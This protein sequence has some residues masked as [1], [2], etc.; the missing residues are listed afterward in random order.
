MGGSRCAFVCECACV[1]RR[2]GGLRCAHLTCSKVYLCTHVRK[3]RARRVFESPADR[4]IYT[5]THTRA[6]THTHAHTHTCK[7]THTHTYAHAPPQHTPP[8]HTPCTDSVR[9]CRPPSKTPRTDFIATNKKTLIR[10]ASLGPAVCC[11]FGRAG[12]G[13]VPFSRAE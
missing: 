5:H 11:I 3:L 2:V 7:L 4:V 10:Y 13:G 8:Q 9:F 1:D 6:H 12:R